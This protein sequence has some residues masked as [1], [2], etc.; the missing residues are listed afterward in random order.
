MSGNDIRN[1]AEIVGTDKAYRHFVHRIHKEFDIADEERNTHVYVLY[2]K[3]G[4]GKTVGFA[5]I[6]HSN[7]K[8]RVWEK[9]MREE[10]WVKADFKM[11][12]PC[13]ELMYMYVKPRFRK[14]GL[15]TKLFDKVL[16]FTKEERIKGIYAYVG[17]KSPRAID[18]Y[19]DN[20][21]VVLTNL[22]SDGVANAFLEWRVK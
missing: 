18:F 22:S 4:H 9:T 21:G 7:S 8:M 5:V 11:T 13:F 6:G 16:D 2:Q 10:G 17:D 12:R 3:D 1:I 19:E 15:G 20:G 14:K